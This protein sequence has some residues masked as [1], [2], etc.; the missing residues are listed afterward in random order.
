MKNERYQ[1]FLESDWYKKHL[2]KTPKHMIKTTEQKNESFKI[3]KL[4]KVA[5]HFFHKSKSI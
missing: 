4:S 2:T 5:S 1:K 3:R